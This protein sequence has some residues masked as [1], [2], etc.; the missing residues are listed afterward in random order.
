[1]A[2][3]GS[4]CAPR[5]PSQESELRG[6][7]LRSGRKAQWLFFNF[8][9]HR[10]R[11]GESGLKGSPLRPPG[12]VVRGRQVHVR[13]SWAMSTQRRRAT[14]A[15]R[16]QP[17]ENCGF[18]LSHRHHPFP[19]ARYGESEIT[20]QLCPNCHDIYHLIGS[21]YAENTVSQ[22]LLRPIMRSSEL[23]DRIF[24]PLQRLYLEVAKYDGAFQQVSDLLVSEW[25]DVQA[26]LER[27]E[28]EEAIVKE[29]RRRAGVS[30]LDE[31]GL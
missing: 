25:D 13:L 18:P 19:V 16:S 8:R 12:Q 31:Q 7:P 21:A 3:P 24:R 5:L 14:I 23:A 1:M 6:I 26:R 27:G 17:C 15:E 9:R 22:A 10:D 28:T 30:W 4:A 2:R 11:G 29:Y 20:Y